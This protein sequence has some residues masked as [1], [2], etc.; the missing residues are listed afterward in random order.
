MHIFC[1]S[2]IDAT[3][4][5]FAYMQ[6]EGK[7]LGF[8]IAGGVGSPH[9]AG[10]DS[11][12]VSKIIPKSVA[13]RDGRLSVGDRVL[14]VLNTPC[15]GLTHEVGWPRPLYGENVHVAGVIVEP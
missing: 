12:F 13:D 3:D 11:I 7:G 8:T 15:S 1:V 4:V 10:D 2:F 5:S 9:V 14:S 6:R